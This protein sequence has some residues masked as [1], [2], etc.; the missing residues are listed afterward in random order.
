[1]DDGHR[2]GG[3]LPSPAAAAVDRSH[4]PA[5][6]AAPQKYR[7]RLQASNLP[8]AAA[9]AGGASGVFRGNAAPDVFAV[10]ASASD[11]HTILSGGTASSSSS[12]TSGSGGVKVWGQ[13]EVLHKCR[14]PQWTQT[15]TLEC[16][17]SCHFYVHVFQAIGRKNSVATSE[18]DKSFSTKKSTSSVLI[19][20]A[21]FHASDVLSTRNATRCKRLRDGGC[22]FCRME[23]ILARHRQQPH[24][25]SSGVS[26]TSHHLNNNAIH[27]ASSRITLQFAATNLLVSRRISILPTIATASASSRRRPVDTILEIAVKT[28]ALAGWV[29]VVRSALVRQSLDPVYEPMTHLTLDDL[30]GGGGGSNHNSNSHLDLDRH[31]RIL[32]YAVKSSAAAAA[33]TTNRSLIGISETT[34]RHL[35]YPATAKTKS[36]SSD[37]PIL[38]IQNAINGSVSRDEEEGELNEAVPKRTVELLLQRNSNKPKEVGRIRIIQAV[39][40]ADEDDDDG[41]FIHSPEQAPASTVEVVDLM[42][43]VPL[44][45]PSNH[46][47]A[48]SFSSYMQEG[49]QI[50]FCVAID[51]TSSNGDPTKAGSYHYQSQNTMNDYEETISAIGQSLA[52]YSDNDEY[53]VWGFGAKFGNTVRHIFQCGA[54]PTVKGINGILTAYQSMFQDDLIMSGPTDFTLVLQAAAAR[55]KRHHQ[56][57]REQKHYTILLVVTDGIMDNFEET[58]QRLDLY[59][60]MPLSIVFVGI[61]RSDF[62]LMHELCQMSTS[63]AKTR[64]ITTFV[65]FCQHQDNPS[66]LGEA[67]LRNIPTQLYGYMQMQG[68]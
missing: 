68:I 46:G 62:A 11:P 49:C 59:S 42:H 5:A 36:S 37:Q 19:G 60:S 66:A 56:A 17:P 24:N 61:G 29:V 25:S 57:M 12:S 53:V 63:T 39:I 13:T 43:L 47:T 48:R 51:F 18:K 64:C 34:V 21:L 50:D 23:P 4:V 1:M 54:T 38:D 7:I 10:V 41:S 14:N 67:A 65:T 30:C 27:H 20:T 45:V 3:M 8:S 44:A 16:V 28:T 32:I 2:G 58:R 31:L 6:A 33:T 9:A 52:R 22:V 26:S 55:A 15:V 40:H 35:L